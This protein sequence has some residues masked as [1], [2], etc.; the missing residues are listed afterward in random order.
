M[1]K[2][3]TK[4]IKSKVLSHE[5]KQFLT[6]L[7]IRP[8]KNFMSN[9]SRLSKE[10]YNRGYTGEITN[11]NIR[12]FIDNLP[13]EEPT[14]NPQPPQPP[15]EPPQ[16]EPKEPTPTPPSEPETYDDTQ[17]DQ[18]YPTPSDEQ[19]KADD[20]L[21]AELSRKYAKLEAENK[22]LKHEKQAMLTKLTQERREFRKRLEDHEAAMMEIEVFPD[23]RTQ[24]S[25]EERVRRRARDIDEVTEGLVTTHATDEDYKRNREL[26]RFIKSHKPEKIQSP[27]GFIPLFTVDDDNQAAF[28][29]KITDVFQK[30]GNEHNNTK[31]DSH[32]DYFLYY[33][34]NLSSMEA[35][36]DALESVYEKHQ[37]FPFKITCDSGF[38][39]EQHDSD[40]CSYKYQPPAEMVSGRSIPMTIAERH[41]LELYKH[42]IY[43]YITE[44]TEV[45]HENSRNRYCAIVSFMFKV[46]PLQRTGK[47][48]SKLKLA[49]DYD[50]LLHDNRFVITDCDYNICVFNTIA[51]GLLLQEQSK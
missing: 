35:L 31:V 9:C 36:F 48:T 45:T 5:V 32:G 44:K 17:D 42:Y 30:N 37:E 34:N 7:G 4:I 3:F 18:S 21:F 39:L 10:L 1:E 26:V 41:D 20:D 29:S 13:T 46:I 25:T 12:H 16:P 11:E 6:D 15:E 28:Q 2:Q 22:R 51:A 47:R 14:P 8:N 19:R 23:T 49:A 33:I 27:D 38:I 40:S 43:S 50:W 24:L